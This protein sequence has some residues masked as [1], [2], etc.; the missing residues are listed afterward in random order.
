M[1]DHYR[2]IYVLPLLRGIR[3]EFLERV[4][5]SIYFRLLIYFQSFV[6]T[7][8]SVVSLILHYSKTSVRRNCRRTRDILLYIVHGK[9]FLLYFLK[10]Y[11]P[12]GSRK[13]YSV[14]SGIPKV[15]GSEFASL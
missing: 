13:S 12:H 5:A 9:S 11:A 6:T 8:T 14:Q 10:N 4:P 3:V 7:I 1:N 2:I 15:Q